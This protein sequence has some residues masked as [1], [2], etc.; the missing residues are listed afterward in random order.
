MARASSS[1][2]RVVSGA[3]DSPIPLRNP[4]R[5][6]PRARSAFSSWKTTRRCAAWRSASSRGSDISVRQ[7]PDGKSAL[8]I[9]GTDSID[10]LFTDMIMSN[11]VSGQDWLR[12]RARCGRASRCSSRRGIRSSSCKDASSADV[13]GAAAQQTLSQRARSPKPC[14]A[15]SMARLS[16]EHDLFRKPVP[17]FRD[18][19][20][21]CTCILPG[22]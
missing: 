16:S 2:C 15:C 14:A 22:E 1:I 21:C 17:T 3:T 12:P 13:R 5:P 10:L 20:H 8:D 18:H 6:S 9:L 7:A 19:A 11:G 4:R